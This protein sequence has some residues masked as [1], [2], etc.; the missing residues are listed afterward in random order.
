MEVSHTEHSFAQYAESCVD[1]ERQHS[2][3]HFL[4]DMDAEYTPR[5]RT[6]LRVIHGG[7]NDTGKVDRPL[8][9]L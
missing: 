6:P 3:T 1:C 9:Q 5:H 4:I 2:L 8:P 7:R